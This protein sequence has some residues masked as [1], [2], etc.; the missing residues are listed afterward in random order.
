M[1]EEKLIAALDN[2]CDQGMVLFLANPADARNIA[3]ALLGSA[4]GLCDHTGL[5]VDGFVAHLRRTN[6][7]PEAFIPPGGY[8]KTDS[9]VQQFVIPGSDISDTRPAKPEKPS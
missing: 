2:I 3:C 6:G 8:T 4:I 9:W 1:P 5:D 7:E